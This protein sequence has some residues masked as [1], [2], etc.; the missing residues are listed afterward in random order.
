MRVL[1]VEDDLTAARGISLML[2][3]SGAVV[4]HTDTGEEALE[5]ARHYEYDIVL[6][7]IMLPDIEGYEV[8]RRLRLARNDTPVLILSGLARPQAKVKGLGMGADDYITKPFDRAEL[9][10]RMQA[11]VRRCKGFSQ[12]ALCVGPLQLNLDSREVTVDGKPVHLTGKEYAILELLVLRKG[13]VLTKEAFLNHLYGGMDEPEM[14]IIDVFICKLRKKLMQAGADN[15]IGTVWGRGYMVREPSSEPLSLPED[16]M[17]DEL[18]V[19]DHILDERLAA[20]DRLEG[21][22]A[23]TDALALEHR[24]AA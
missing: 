15:M 11:I 18:A 2:K 9:L 12:P 10:A 1:L 22:E 16:T 4:D 20:A 23:V 13:M 8:V 14:K 19:P 7:D 24:S 6:L 5:L 17:E 21:E 3:S